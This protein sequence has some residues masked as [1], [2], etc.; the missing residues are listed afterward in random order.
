[1]SAAIGL[2]VMVFF[3]FC[4]YYTPPWVGLCPPA[5][6]NLWCA[7]CPCRMAWLAI[8]NKRVYKRVFCTHWHTLSLRDEPFCLM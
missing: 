8:L 7:Q 1:L 3:Q 2:D 5:L 4:D 6:H